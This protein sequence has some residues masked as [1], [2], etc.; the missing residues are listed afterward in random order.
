M[1]RSD[2]VLRLTCV[3]CSSTLMP[4]GFICTRGNTQVSSST[5]LIPSSSES[6]DWFRSRCLIWAEFTTSIIR[7]LATAE[8]SCRLPSCHRD[9]VGVSVELEDCKWE[10]GQPDLWV[11]VFSVVWSWY[12]CC[13]GIE[14]VIQWH[15][16]TPTTF[17]NDNFS[18][19]TFKK[20]LRLDRGCQTHFT[21][22]VTYSFV[23]KWAR[24]VKIP[25]L[26]M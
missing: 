20:C 23:F 3:T 24:K 19:I 12:S 16:D 26:S 2:E 10:T 5:S 25:F 22:W 6:S 4:R 1:Y 17:L 13:R 15:C 18:R 11:T 21:S 8:K 14:S 9:T 7:F